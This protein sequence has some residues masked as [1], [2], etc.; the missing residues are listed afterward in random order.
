MRFTRW[1]GTLLA[2]LALWTTSQASIFRRSP[3]LDAINARLNGHVDDYTNNHRVD[4]RVW[5]E[6]LQQKRDL[7]VYLPP[8]Y[9]PAKQYPVILYLH[10]FTQ[11]ESHFLKYIVPLFD[12]AMCDGR[13][14]PAIVACPDGSIPGKPAFFR[15]ASF[16]ANTNAGCFEDYLMGEV[17]PFVLERYPIRPERDAHAIV[18]GSMG[19]SAAFRIAFTHADDFRS[20]V[21]I[22]PAVN[23]RWVDC[24]DRYMSPFDPECWGWRT[25]V[26]P[27]E[28]VGKFYGGAIKVR[29]KYL[30]QPLFGRGRQVID[31]VARINPTE[32]LDAA[33][34]QPGQFDMYIAYGDKDQFNIGAHVQS[35]AARARQRGVA[36]TVECLPGG[37]HDVETGTK[38]FPWAVDWIAPRLAP[39]SPR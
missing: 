32:V 16:F 34:V 39:Y 37:K 25:R 29:F 28:V 20:I 7:Y 27:N 31:G 2:L 6:A 17:W 38:L 13:L 4:R 23:L 15:S 12:A 3:D 33:D 8:G 35:F 26:H 5:S 36:V 24:H 19:G 1:A 21:G 11:D 22:F 14:P 18:G 30:S 10:A 9:D